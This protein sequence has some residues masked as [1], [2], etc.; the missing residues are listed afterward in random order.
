MFGTSSYCIS[1]RMLKF[2]GKCSYFLFST[3]FPE[4]TRDTYA[5][6]LFDN[7]EIPHDCRSFQI[8][9]PEVRRIC[10]AYQGIIDENPTLAKYNF[11]K[12]LDA[13]FEALMKLEEEA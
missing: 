5:R 12:H 10:F 13:D 1:Q 6:R 8:T 3:L 4:P 11:R 7:A 2:I 9:M